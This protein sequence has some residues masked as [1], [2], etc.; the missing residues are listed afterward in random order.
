MM[1]L[2]KAA[3]G[4]HVFSFG[5]SRNATFRGLPGLLADS[6]PDRFGEELMNVWLLA[7]GREIGTSNPVERLCY[8]GIRGMGALGCEPAHHGLERSGETLQIDELV[9]VATDVLYIRS[10]FA[11]SKTKGKRQALRDII[12]WHLCWWS[13]GESDRC[14]QRRNSEVR[15]GQI[16]DHKGFP[17]V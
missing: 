7:Q 12:Q 4:N 8:M 9:R 3:N 11:T 6:L 5:N 10:K 13:A 15:S 16:S 1:P 17:Y 14:L 2:S